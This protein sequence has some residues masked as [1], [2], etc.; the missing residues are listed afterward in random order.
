[1]STIELPYTAEL[2]DGMFAV[3]QHASK[4]NATPIITMVKVCPRFFVATN[5]YTVGRWEHNT[6]AEV[7][8]VT[9]EGVLVNDPDAVVLIPR[10]A[11]EW[12]AKQTP[13]VLGV[14]DPR[15]VAG[16]SYVV[17][18]T[19]ES[20]TIKWAGPEGEVLAVTRFEVVT[21]N[22]PP[23]ERLIPEVTAEYAP[24]DILPVVSLNPAH[25]EMFIRGAKRTLYREAP[26]RFRLTKTENPS[27]PGPVVITF[28]DRFVG[29]LQPN[30][31]T[32]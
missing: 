23:V 19:P 12:L 22:F 16:S 10:K 24:E 15:L 29:L 9:A 25:L 2:L 5:R 31:L 26:M 30:L 20:V 6:E 14:T 7:G 27:K 8:P 3:A 21:G 4:D 18:F 32:R 28:A 1:M 17:V 13:K 11:A